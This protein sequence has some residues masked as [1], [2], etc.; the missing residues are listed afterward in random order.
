[1]KTG[2]IYL[3]VMLELNQDVSESEADELTQELDYEFKDEKGRIANTEI[4]AWG[5]TSDV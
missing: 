5:T 2:V 3:K 1:M 4:L